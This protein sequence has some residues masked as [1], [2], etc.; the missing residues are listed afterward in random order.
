MIEDAHQ[1]DVSEF[2]DLLV[3]GPALLLADLQIDDEIT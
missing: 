3:L 1:R 2:R